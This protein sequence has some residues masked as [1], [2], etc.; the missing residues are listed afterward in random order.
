MVY[1]KLSE[2][3]NSATANKKKIN[4]NPTIEIKNHIEELV[5]NILDPLRAAW[6][7][8]IKVTSGYRCPA[9]NKAVGGAKASAHLTGYAADIKPVN[10]RMKEFYE[11]VKKFLKDKQFD[12]L[13]NEYPNK[14]GVPSWVH[15]GYKNLKGMQR[16][17]LLTIK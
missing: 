15:I 4:N 10:G 9:L 6:G 12:Q 5:D 3:I 11:F 8:G 14:N 17:Q 7:S 2:F 16:K 13:I 1:F